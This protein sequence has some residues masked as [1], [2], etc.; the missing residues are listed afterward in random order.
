M[1]RF[2]DLEKKIFMEATY[3]ERI[4]LQEERDYHTHYSFYSLAVD[5]GLCTKED[6]K[7]AQDFY[8]DNWHYVGD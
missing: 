5:L 6:M 3:K 2:F 8:A 1:K 7:A 4:A